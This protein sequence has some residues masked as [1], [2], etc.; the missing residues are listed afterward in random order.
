V[1]ALLF[2]KD[3]ALLDPDDNFTVQTVCG[4][5]DHMLRKVNVDT[6]LRAMLEEFKKVRK[7]KYL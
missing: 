7:R 6:P 4:Y 2:V 3:L 5:H 1:I